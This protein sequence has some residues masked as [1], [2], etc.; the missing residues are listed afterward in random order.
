MHSVNCVRNFLSI[1]FLL[2]NNCIAFMKALMFRKR[3]H[4]V[5][6]AHGIFC[7]VIFFYCEIHAK[8]CPSLITATRINP[9]KR[10][11]DILPPP[12]PKKMRRIRKRVY[13]DGPLSVAL[14]IGFMGIKKSPADL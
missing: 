5:M 3:N 7:R 11:G 1:W 6:H 13:N 2:I 10:L 12:L 8:R 9:R 4:A 14:P